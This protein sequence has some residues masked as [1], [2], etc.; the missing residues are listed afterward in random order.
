[1]TLQGAGRQAEGQDHHGAALD[2]P[3][4][5]PSHSAPAD[6]LW[7]KVP[8]KAVSVDLKKILKKKLWIEVDDDP[9]SEERG[10]GKRSRVTFEGFMSEED[11]DESEPDEDEDDEDDDDDEDEEDE[12]EEDEDEDED[13]EEEDDEDE[14]DDDDDEEEEGR[15]KSKRQEVIQEEGVQE[16]GQE[17]GQEVKKDDDETSKS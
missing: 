13:D 3:E 1:V 9:S 8:K 12:E 15:K 6:R 2:H 11:Y 5:S 17:E 14:D 7:D 10:Y 4:G 16:Q